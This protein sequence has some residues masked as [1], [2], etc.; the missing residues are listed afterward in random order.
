MPLDA[1]LNKNYSI[2]VFLSTL[3]MAFG[4]FREF[5]IVGLLGFTVKNDGLQAYLSI[6][7]TIGLS[8]DAM[9]LAC[10]N[11]YSQL[12]LSRIVF[13]ASMIGLPFAIAVGLMMN[14]STHGLDT[15]LLV[16]AIL[17]S[18][19][20]LIATLLITYKQRNNLFLAAQIINVLPNFILIPG[21]LCC[22]WFA[23]H[24]I[25]LAIVS[26]TSAIPIVQCIFLLL[27]PSHQASVKQNDLSLSVTLLT[28]VRHLSAMTGEQ[29]LQIIT[30]AAFFNYGPG[31]LS[32]YAMAIRIYAALRFIL[33][34]S[35]IGSRLAS[36]K[37]D[38]DQNEFL[39]TKMINSKTISLLIVLL[40]LCVSLYPSVQLWKATLQMG[41]LLL[42][43]FYFS[44]LV[45]IVYFKINRHET[46][47]KLVWRY[48]L[49]ELSFALVAF[50]L[51]TSSHYPLLA[52]L[53]IGFIAKPFAQLIFLRRRFYELA[54]VEGP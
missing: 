16:I 8:I 43:G 31:Y 22:Y 54:T 32:L 7:Y 23:S 4:I 13:T 37:K 20:N 2:A 30:R 51:T 15:K 12:T 45:R 27:L 50:M 53:W 11:L 33:I 46:N 25:V 40:A 1:N 3:S 5:L 44:T 9:R 47:S 39:L 52:L 34:D 48:A 18:Y 42:G 28:F 26:L 36:W 6:F 38:L 41:I 10:L 19:F 14:F 21:I 35:Y 24:N 29:L 49:Y 17:G